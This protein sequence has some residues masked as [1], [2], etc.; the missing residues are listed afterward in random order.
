MA[1]E[2]SRVAVCREPTAHV[3]YE[4]SLGVAQRKPLLF[5]GFRARGDRDNVIKLI[6]TGEK[7]NNLYERWGLVRPVAPQV[8]VA[9]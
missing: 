6:H 4:W 9:S 8:A 7:V 1:D 2:I 5:S 3:L